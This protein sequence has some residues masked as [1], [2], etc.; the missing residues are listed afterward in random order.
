MKSTKFIPALFWGGVLS[1]GILLST[2]DEVSGLEI[3]KPGT[4]ITQGKLV[5]HPRLTLRGEYDDNIFLSDRGAED[6]LIGILIPGV[7]VE[8]P[9]DNNYL[10]LDYQAFLH[11]YKD[12]TD[13]NHQDHRLQGLCSLVFSPLTLKIEDLFWKTSSR[14]NTDFSNLV[15]RIENTGSIALLYAANAFELQGRYKNFY[16]DYD[17]NSYRPYDHMEH[18]GILTGFYQVAPKT[19]ALIEYTYDR[20]VYREDRDRDG[21]YNEV[22]GGFVG[23]L[24]SKLTGTAKVGYQSRQY[25]DDSVWDDYD[26]IVGYVLLEQVFSRNSDLRVGWERSTHESTWER[27][28]YY[29][30]NKGWLAYSQQLAHKIRGFARIQYSNYRYPQESA[31][32]G[33]KRRDDIW[34]PEAG[35]QYQIQAWLSAEFRYIYKVRDSNLPGKDYQDNRFI[36]ELSATY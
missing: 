12:H 15:K 21:Y 34:K 7:S 11:Y 16:Q 26:G 29:L 14:E 36:L 27:N 32:Y 19:K 8:L 30:L 13:Q 10:F 17:E 25:Y 28:S 5:I 18:Y 35:I 1:V 3:G 4:G 23:E 24:A 22:R 2:T 6:D 20:I 31:F 9:W 33:K